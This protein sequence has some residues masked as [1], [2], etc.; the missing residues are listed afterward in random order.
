MLLIDFFDKLSEYFYGF[1][2]VYL[3]L[4]DKICLFV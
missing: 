3:F 4:V 1:I 2:C